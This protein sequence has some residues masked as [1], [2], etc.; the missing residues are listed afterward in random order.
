VIAGDGPGAD[1]DDGVS[2]ERTAL[3]W[4]R[5][6]LSLVACGVIMARGLGGVDI[7]ARPEVGMVVAGVGGALWLLA[8]IES[9]RRLREATGPDRAVVTRAE[10]AVFSLACTAAGLVAFTIALLL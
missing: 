8:N 1:W 7:P 4:R 9:R 6:G 2:A 5:S 3:A 10:L